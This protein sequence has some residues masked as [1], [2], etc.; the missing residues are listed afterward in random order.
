MAEGITLDQALAAVMREPDVAFQLKEALSNP[1]V[2]R[3]P[4]RRKIAEFVSEFID[5]YDT[6]PKEGDYVEWVSGLNDKQRTGVNK[7]LSELRNVDLSEFTTE[8]LAKKAME[9]FR[10]ISA[11]NAVHH[12]NTM[13]DD[14]DAESLINMAHEVEGI[15]PITISGIANLRDVDMWARR[16]SYDRGIP[17]GIPS[18][19]GVTMGWQEG[20]LGFILADSGVGKSAA[21]VN[22]AKA[23]ALTGANVLHLT[24]ELSQENTAIRF[25]RSVTEASSSEYRSS[26]EQVRKDAKYWWRFAEG[27]VHVLYEEPYTLRPEDLKQLITLYQRRYGEVDMLCLDYLDLMAPSKEDSRLGTY[28]QLGRVSHKVRGYAQEFGFTLLSATQA[29]RP[30]GEEH[31]NLSL[32]HMGDSY[33]KV[34][35]A[36]IIIGFV[37]TQQEVEARQGRYQMLKMRENPGRGADIP[38][39]VNLDLMMIADLD[40]PNTRVVMRRMG[41][42]VAPVH[43]PEEEEDENQQDRSNDEYVYEHG[44][45]G[46]C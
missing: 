2:V 37:R 39:Y 32:S 22:H 16:D 35:A 11:Q 1:L 24:L 21:L 26:N 45:G 42:S 15:E 20:E 28:E 46:F 41:D 13:G 7:A 5:E 9:K 14:V 8:Y 40:H 30:Q 44:T 17:T 31:S 38:L 25:Y 3:S 10:K 34:R 18:L 33:K 27:N 19:D 12:L 23:A 6:L 4:F 29:R 43:V 36:D